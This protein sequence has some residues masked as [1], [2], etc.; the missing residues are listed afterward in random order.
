LLSRS[1]AEDAWATVIEGLAAFVAWLGAAIIVLA[2]GR[3]GLALGLALITVAFATLAWAGGETPG[4]AA[5][6]IGGAV[7]SVRG[8]RSGAEGWGL[9]PP[10]STPRLVLSVAVGLVAL[11][12]AGSVTFGA[13][14]PARFAGLAVLG[15]MGAR[16]LASSDTA[17]V[18]VAVAG[19]A[20]ALA[21]STAMAA[22]SPGPSP[23][24]AGALVAAGVMIL[25]R[26][27][28]HAG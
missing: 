14:A 17:I 23:Y 1:R 22:T 3:R 6:L 27:E 8:L 19:V 16:A 24:I 21:E 25:P 7:A 13:G 9:M 15:L 28:P 20:L 11:W 10:G 2:D 12:F 26:S 4:A 18:L 5:L